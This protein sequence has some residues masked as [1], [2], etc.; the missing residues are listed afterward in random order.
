M[1]IA[2][3]TAD[4]RLL[5]RSARSTVAAAAA[6]VDM[7]VARFHV[8]AAVLLYLSAARLIGKQFCVHVGLP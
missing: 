2:V 6:F 3:D 1:R 7:T 8:V 4:T 5:R